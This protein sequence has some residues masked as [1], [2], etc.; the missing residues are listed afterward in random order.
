[1]S[2]REIGVNADELQGIFP[3]TVSGPTMIHCTTVNAVSI[4]HQLSHQ[5]R[6]A[7]VPP[8]DRAATV[9]RGQPR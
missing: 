2:L 4:R 3:L 9:R 8:W 5:I 7:F 1:M 6:P